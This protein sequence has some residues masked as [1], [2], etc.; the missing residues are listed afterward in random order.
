MPRWSGRFRD[1]RLLRR[2]VF[3]DYRLAPRAAI[4][5]AGVLVVLIAISAT[6]SR[7]APRGVEAHLACA[8]R[9]WR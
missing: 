4:V 9:R 1:P 7:V 2:P 3:N 8:G 6:R 5:G